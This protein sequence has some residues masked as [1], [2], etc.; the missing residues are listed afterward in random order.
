M[1]LLSFVQI[2]I[3]SEIRTN[4]THADSVLITEITRFKGVECVSNPFYG[5]CT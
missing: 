1:D 2:P 3:N 4:S 5:S